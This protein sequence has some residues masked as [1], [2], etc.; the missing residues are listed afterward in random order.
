VA[1]GGA[2]LFGLG[3]GGCG[4]GAEQNLHRGLTP[5]TRCGRNSFWHQRWAS[6]SPPAWRP[7]LVLIAKWLESFKF[8]STYHGAPRILRYAFASNSN[9]GSK[10]L[11]AAVEKT[12]GMA[13]GR[14]SGGPSLAVDPERVNLSR[15]PLDT[16]YA[17]HVGFTAYLLNQRRPLGMVFG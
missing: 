10:I 4:G 16:V 15:P 17:A 7:A 13:A 9:S 8:V 11:S 12:S 5:K 2:V 6:K 1:S 14:G 3:G